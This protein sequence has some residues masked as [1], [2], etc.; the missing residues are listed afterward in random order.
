MLSLMEC[1]TAGKWQSWISAHCQVHPEPPHYTALM[2]LHPQ[3]LH[4]RALMELHP[5]P[6]HY[7][8]LMEAD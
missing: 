2:E 7:T 4:Y 5:H 1:H 8:A 3:P 6:P